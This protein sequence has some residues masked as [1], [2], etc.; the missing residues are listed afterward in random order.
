[1]TK[2]IVIIGNGISGITAAR[3]IR[4]NSDDKIT[5]V[6]SETEYF[7]SRTALMYI[8]MGHMKFEHTKPY[9]DW[10]WKK[11]RIDL[12]YDHVESVD[13]NNNKIITKT[14]ASIEYDVLVI[15]SGS[16]PNKFGWPGQELKGVHGMYGKPDL[17]MLEKYSPNI[18]QAVVVGGG[19]IG[20]ELVEMLLSRHIDVNF[21]V[22]EKSFWSNVLPVEESEMINRIIRSHH[23]NLQLNTELKEIKG[24]DNGYVKSIIDS[25]GQKI[26]CQFVGLTVGVSPNISFLEGTGIETD[27]GVLVNEYLETNVQSIYAIGDCVQHRTPPDG[28]KSVEQVWYTGRIMG[29]TIAQTITG[30]RQPYKPGVWFNSAKF[31]DTEYQTYGWVFPTL[32]ENEDTWYM[33]N[34]KKSQALRLVFLKENHQLTGVNAFGIR[35]KHEVLDKWITEKI[36][37]DYMLEN[38]DKALFDPEFSLKPDFG[39]L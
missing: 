31:F 23:V 3:N 39:N 27:R 21:L 12:V 2:H 35:L 16:K 8:Y 38:M 1:M 32:S 37:A 4:K 25:N 11:N 36:S 26:P 17:D 33:E 5:V 13:T 22:R 18:S 15:A 14:G 19:L 34:E 10:F 6:S 7:F 28:R 20:I 24:D 9:E 29:E 30:D